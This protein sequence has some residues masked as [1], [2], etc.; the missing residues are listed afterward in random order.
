M[1]KY[2]LGAGAATPSQLAGSTKHQLDAQFAAK[3]VPLHAKIKE[4]KR[5]IEKLQ[6][7]LGVAR[8]IEHNLEQTV[9]ELEINLTKAKADAAS[10]DK[11]KLFRL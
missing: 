9:Q 6:N 5:D 8:T 2:E 7:E 11:S 3:E 10:G 1:W 4:Q